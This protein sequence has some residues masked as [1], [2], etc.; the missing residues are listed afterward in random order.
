[1]VKPRKRDAGALFLAVVMLVAGILTLQRGQ[2]SWYGTVGI[3]GTH[4]QVFG[5][6]SI[7]FSVV[8][9]LVYVKGRKED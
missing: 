8:I 5:W 7:A 9:F 6:A 3:G 2:A 1:M 4:A